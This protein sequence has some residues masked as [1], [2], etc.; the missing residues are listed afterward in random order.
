MGKE[1][2]DQKEEGPKA[3]SERGWS[4]RWYESLLYPGRGLES[5]EREGEDKANRY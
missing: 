5:L 4:G 3:D 1:R 2:G